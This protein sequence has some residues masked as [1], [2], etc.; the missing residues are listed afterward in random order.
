VLYGAGTLGGTP[1]SFAFTATDLDPGTD[2]VEMEV[3]ANGS[4]HLY[5]WTC[6]PGPS[7]PCIEIQVT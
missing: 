4:S 3:T 5:H 1:A 7:Q 6:T 2:S